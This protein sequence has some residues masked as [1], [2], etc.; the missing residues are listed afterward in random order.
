MYAVVT[1]GLYIERRTATLPW[2]AGAGAAINLAICVVAQSR[3]GM[4]GVAWATPASY[5]LMAGL[6]AWQSGRVYPVP[7]EWRRLAHLAVNV[8]PLFA[9]DRWI[10]SRGV[11]PLSGVGLAL[12]SA[13]LLAFPVLLLITG[14]FRPGEWKL[15]RSM[16]PSR[17]ATSAG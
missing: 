11:P 3:W 12:K 1:T 8:A 10:A 6:G 17:R 7:F 13:L 5:A 9:A 4:V 14:F 2:V 15:M 16:M